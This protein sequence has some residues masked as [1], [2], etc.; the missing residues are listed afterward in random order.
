MDDVSTGEYS[1]GHC[2]KAKAQ[3]FAG[4]LFLVKIVG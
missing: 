3:T 1:G 4:F 2:K